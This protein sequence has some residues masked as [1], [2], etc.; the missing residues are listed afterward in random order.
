[1]L[2]RQLFDAES[3]SY[4]YL[5]AD[6]ASRQAALIDSVYGQVDRDATLIRE[7]E[8]DLKYLLETHIHADHVTGTEVLKQ[9]FPGARSVISA[10]SGCACADVSVHDGDSLLLGAYSIWILA[11]PGHTRGCLSYLAEDKVFTGDTL[12]IR[13]C[14][15]TDFQEGD[16]GQLYDSITQ[17]LFT[18]PSATL[19]YPGHNYAGLTVS[20]IGEEK[21]LNPRLAGK[22]RKQ[23]MAIMNALEL[24]P[25]KKIHEAVPANLSC[26][27]LQA[28]S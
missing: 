27:R 18:L 11:T 14:G 2:F 12:L 1:M 16:P 23:F 24:P 20:S 13:G 19:V 10:Q 22:S 5:L 6:P 8:L 7:L 15:R 4:T 21:R 26:G 17:K 3:G 9:R 25:P 28:T